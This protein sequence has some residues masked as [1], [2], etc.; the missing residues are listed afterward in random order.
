VAGF[1]DTVLSS[2]GSLGIQAYGALSNTAS[3]GPMAGANNMPDMPQIWP[4]YLSSGL[5]NLRL[6]SILRSADLGYLS[7]LMTLLQE[8]AA[9]DPLIRGMFESRQSSLVQRQ[10]LCLPSEADID[11]V[12]AKT[13][14]DYGNEV[15][16]G[17]NI[18]R[19]DG[20]VYK[21]ERGLQGVVEFLDSYWWYGFANGYLQ[22]EILPGTDYP[23]PVG[24]EPIDHRRFSVDPVDDSFQLLT[25]DNAI[26]GIPLRCLG[27]AHIV[28]VRNSR[29]SVP[30]A[31]AGIGRAVTYPWHL[32]FNSW[33]NLV[34][35]EELV[36]VPSPF[37][38]LG[39][40]STF[41][42]EITAKIRD[43]ARKY[44]GGTSVILPPGAEAGFFKTPD[45]VEKLFAFID[46]MTS[47]ALMYAILGQTGTASGQGGSLAK[48]QVNA[49]TRED[50]IRGDASA[51]EAALQHILRLATVY[52]F[53]YGVPAPVVQFISDD[54]VLRGV[55]LEYLAK[56][57]S[58]GVPVT[59]KR[60]MQEGGFD[61]PEDLERLADGNRWSKALQARIDQTGNVVTT[62]PSSAPIWIGAA[63]PQTGPKPK[64]NKGALFSL[65]ERLE[66]AVASLL[67]QKPDEPET[68]F[69]IEFK[70][71]L[72]GEPIETK[73]DE[74]QRT[75]PDL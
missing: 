11:P 15:L 42:E 41:N 23:R 17:L 54:T 72:H 19:K 60:V 1:F 67:P 14:A 39:N 35:V 69:K 31:Q 2:L 6:A 24:L 62:K 53:G 7:E 55:R 47:D 75:D 30:I 49:D 59:L 21:R 63:T 36:S 3:F 25:E 8:I 40:I 13:V 43:Y 64:K 73:T 12:R 58:M 37:I 74:A 66:K 20:E 71:P 38:K 5:S 34:F 27:E 9:K 48:A 51:V 28:E 50:I 10:L 52:R 70:T 65:V 26:K 57:I 22:W 45:G 44:I 29:L 33:K 32:R 16:K 56:A 61:E 18:F 46:Q 4:R 68:T